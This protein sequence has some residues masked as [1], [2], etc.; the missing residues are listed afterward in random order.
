MSRAR[1]AAA[2]AALACVALAGAERARFGLWTTSDEP[3]HLTAARA[4]RHGPGM[5]SN[6]E[7][8]VLM[9]VIAGAALPAAK[10]GLEV[11]ETRAGRAPFP[12]VL[13]LLVVA[14]GLLGHAVAGP[15]AGLAA[16]G[17]LAVEPTFRGH[18]T[19]VQSDVLV[20]LFL[21]AAA[22]A[23]EEAARAAHSQKG[24]L[25]ASGVLYGL[26][27]ASKYSA[28]PFLA[29][30]ALVAALRLG[31]GRFSSKVNGGRAAGW[32]EAASAAP[33]RIDR[34]SP[35]KKK[36]R[37]AKHDAR[38]SRSAASLSPLHL[39]RNSFSF[40]VLS[41]VAL[42]AAV[43]LA[44]LALVQG[45]AYAGTSDAAFDEGLRAAFRN[46][47][48]ERA[49][50]SLA[51]T[52]P[53]WIAGYGAGL[54]F[55]KGVAGPGERFNYFLGEVRGTGSLLYFPVA[56]AIKLT[57]ATVLGGLAALAASAVAFFR[58]GR[59]RRLLA[60][61]A[62]PAALGAAYLAAAC[63]SNVNIGVRHALPAVPF[64]LVA[65]AAAGRALL[66][67][68]PRAL[69]GVFAAVVLLAAGESA[70]RLG[71]E[72]SFGNLLVGGPSGVP[73]ILSDS[74]VDWGQEQGLLFDR[75]R[76]GDLGRVAMA[77]LLVDE[78]GATRAGILGLALQPD[79]P[80]DTVFFSRFL[81]DLAAAIEKND[82]TYPKFVWLR[83]WLPPLRRGLEARATSIEP[84]GDAY[85]LMRLRPPMAAPSSPPGSTP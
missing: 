55:V 47:P 72:I 24:W 68:R 29:V 51:R 32:A 19:L 6:F 11:D 4:W 85:L 25:V 8:P 10:P 18:G 74:N 2:L 49:V 58:G 78:S 21:V 46:L 61:A 64:L 13:A 1:F 79:A 22:W 56:L 69:R 31:S 16:A 73:A 76:R 48:Q 59:T 41:S 77:S 14:T 84:F 23:V 54:L 81:W 3:A 44:T 70:L 52:F 34:S 63:V 50:L 43:A 26:A 75:V 80:A 60:C 27:M 65:A 45:L 82:E 33:M 37:S 17:L 20:T 36:Q 15:A 7:H 62:L 42:L 57:T 30:F 5:V 9:K 38:S 66:G 53:K 83:G 40:P 71:H 12:F 35:S 28:F 67:R 39:F